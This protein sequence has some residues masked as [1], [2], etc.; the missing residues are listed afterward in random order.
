[1]SVGKLLYRITYLEGGPVCE[2]LFSKICR[3]QG[4]TQ[5]FCHRCQASFLRACSLKYQQGSRSNKTFGQIFYI[6]QPPLGVCVKME[7]GFVASSKWHWQG[8]DDVWAGREIARV[9]GWDPVDWLL[10]GWELGWH[11]LLMVGHT[12]SRDGVGSRDWL[13]RL[14]GVREGTRNMLNSGFSHREAC[15]EA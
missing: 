15:G 9:R 1:M 13:Q 10:M 7:V 14:S 6:F 2:C 4:W 12:W 8:C 5:V 11:G 3:I